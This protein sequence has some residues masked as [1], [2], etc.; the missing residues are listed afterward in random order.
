MRQPPAPR[1]LILAALAACVLSAGAPGDDPGRTAPVRAVI[2]LEDGS[3]LVGTT[4][5]GAFPLRTSYASLSIPLERI[6][7]LQVAENQESVILTLDNGDRIT[8]FAGLGALSLDTSFGKV[9]LPL[10]LVQSCRFRA[11]GSLQPVLH[12]TFDDD[13]PGKVV[14]SSGNRHHGRLSGGVTYAPSFRGQ[15]PRLTRWDTFVVCDSPRLDLSGWS[16]LTLSAWIYMDQ[17]TTY[18]SVIHRGSLEGKR[19]R[20]FHLQAGGPR[21]SFGLAL[22]GVEGRQGA[23]YREPGSE[24]VAGRWYHLVSTY[25]GSRVRLYVDGVEIATSPCDLEGALLVDDPGNSLILG[26]CGSHRLNWYDSYLHG[27]IDEVMI[28][29]RALS[30][31][32]IQALHDELAP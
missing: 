9:T 16:G 20:G 7:S 29:D 3:R 17:K 30:P 13:P 19:N 31:V 26:K 23:A 24:L 5:I 10:H 27:L 25:D 4:A 2:E 21:P 11:A 28:W 15:A 22:E 14:D 32:E 8:G 6:T 1:H 18:G 12:Y